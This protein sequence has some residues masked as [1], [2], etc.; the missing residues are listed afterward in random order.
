MKKKIKLNIGAKLIGG[1]CILLLIV[2]GGMGILSYRTAARA[3]QKTIEEALPTVAEEAALNLRLRLDNYLMG[4][5]GVA[6]RNFIRGMDWELQV[7]AMGKMTKLHGYLGMGIVLPDGLTRYPDGSTAQLGDRQY[8]KDAF[9]GRTVMSDVIISRV[10]QEPVIM[11]A[12]PI[13]N[14]D[15]QI[16]AVLIASLDGFFLSEI[17]DN[18]KYGEQGYSYII[19]D[20]GAV[21]AH[22][23][24]DFVRTAR[25]FL[26]EGRTNED[27]RLLSEMLQRMVRRE[28]GFDEYWFLGFDRLFGYAPIPDTGWSIAVGAIKDEVFTDIYAMRASFSLFSL[29]FIV[30]GAIAAVFFARTISRPVVKMASALKEIAKGDLDVSIDI[31]SKDEV[32]E[33]ALNFSNMIESQKEKSQLIKA[34]SNG[35][36]SQNVKI[37]SDKDIVGKAIQTMINTFK[38]VI[39]RT[40]QTCISQKNGDWDAKNN[41]DGLSG[42]YVSLASGVNEAL[43]AILKPLK[44][45]VNVL[46][47][48]ANGD[49]SKEMYELPGKQII[50]TNGLKNIRNNINQLLDAGAEMYNEQKAGDIEFYIDETKFNGAYKDLASQINESVKLHVNA[51][52]NMLNLLEEYAKGDLS[53]EM[54]E[55]PGKQIIATQRINKLRQ[56]VLNLIDDTKRLSQAGMQGKLDERA[57]ANK[58]D[59][60]F[61]LIVERLN[62][63]L[64]AIVQP[65]AEASSVLESTADNDLTLRMEGQYKGQLAELK[66]NIN[67]TVDKLSETLTSVLSSVLQVNSGVEQI[68][69]AT[70]SLSQGATEQASSLEEISSSMSEISSQIKANAE[71]A[72]TAQNL[73]IDA[74]SAAESGNKRMDEMM[75]AMGEIDGASKQIAK[76]IKVIDDIA[77]QTNLLALNAAVEAARAGS[78]GKGFAVVAD[79]VRNLAGRSAKAAKETADLIE[80]SV[81]KVGNGINIANETSQSFKNIVNGII[82]TTDL[83]GEIAAA[84]NEQAQGASQIG[85]GL[86]QIDSVTQQNTANAE[87]TASAAKELRGQAE[88]LQ[89]EVQRFKLEKHEPAK[90]EFVQK[91]NTASANQNEGKKTK[92]DSAHSNWGNSMANKLYEPKEIILDD[93]EFGRY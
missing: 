11:M 54:P 48:Y 45:A 40:K 67:T 29:F 47:K 28:S 86:S 79:E 88:A 90:K 42:E 37:L 1:I 41:L 74:R 8:V 15:N 33:M 19:N 58:H 56:N 73:S 71:N 12:T 63:T 92:K 60:D 44:D 32:G 31:N 55:L 82:K 83:V 69:D 76:I 24:R 23:N 85:Q 18:I 91:G 68:S 89:N 27:F 53:N 62:S 21:I 26:E 81:S 17:T 16:A 93:K 51:I 35:D 78:H 66:N 38:D 13:R 61:R 70:Q 80:S 2:C 10:T 43:E 30:I 87:E 25:N 5:E 39:E 64:D 14:Q 65:L 7:R 57:D 77:F 72:S 9:A 46:N 75:I 59:G 50:L 6:S 22:G 34:I 20:K 36:F 4:I 49:L 84:S 3:L 52:L